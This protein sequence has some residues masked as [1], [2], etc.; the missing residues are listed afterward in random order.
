KFWHVTL[1]QISGVALLMLVRQIIA[2][3]QVMVEPMAMTG[4]GPNNASITLSLQAYQ[5]AF[6]NFQVDKSL[7]LGVI[8]FL[9]LMVL[10]VFYFKLKN[11]VEDN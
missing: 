2:V 7:A 1:P 11:K 10:T 5:Y 4:G 9:I 3:F 8:T 6:R